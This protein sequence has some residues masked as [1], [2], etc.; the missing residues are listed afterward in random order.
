[1]EK[2]PLCIL[3]VCLGNIC[4]SPIAEGVLVK[5]LKEKGLYHVVVDSCGFEKYHLNDMPDYRS[6]EVCAK[7]DVDISKQRQR[8][9]KV[10]DLDKFDKIY[11]MDAFNYSDVLLY[12]RNDSDKKK[13]DFISNVLTP[14]K[15][16]P[17]PDPFYGSKDDFRKVFETLSDCADE[18]V[19]RILKGKNL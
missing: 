15:N 11:V 16:I 14:G 10:S 18:I 1:M 13:I 4:R 19:D 17:V 7:N 8:L 3:M 2:S 5:K 6:V 9:F 12:V